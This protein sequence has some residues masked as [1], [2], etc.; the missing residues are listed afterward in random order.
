MVF[1][2]EFLRRQKG[3]PTMRKS[4]SRREN[5]QGGHFSRG[6]RVGRPGRAGRFLL[7]VGWGLV[8]GWGVAGREGNLGG[9]ATCRAED[10]SPVSFDTA[11]DEVR[12]KVAD[13]VVAHYV[14]ADPKISRPYLAHVRTVQGVQVTRNHPPIEG[15]DATDHADFHPGVWLAFGDLSGHD[16]W[17]LKAKV[18]HVRFVEKPRAESGGGT[19]EVE[20]EYLESAAIICRERCRISLRPRA[21]GYLLLWESTFRNDAESF[22]FG[23]QE[24]MGLGLRVA[25]PLS[26][27]AGGTILDRQ[28]RRDEK[29]VWGET[30]PWCDYSGPIGDQRAGVT[31]MPAGANFRPSWFHARDYGLLVANPFGRHALGRG[32]TSKVVVEAGKPFKLTFGLWV[33][34]TPPEKQAAAR[35]EAFAAFERL[36]TEETPA[37]ETDT[38]VGKR[39]SDE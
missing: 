21:D 12:I 19:F 25:T 34:A 23:D 4:T 33:Y 20:N 1:R 29:Q 16:D 31:L 38:A 26:V 39:T 14:F 7:V 17:R 3:Q 28:G 6:G 15:Q 2:Y 32:P 36:T 24:E 37:G 11:A 13:R 10:F 22:Y 8:G 30:S 18:R 35:D 9:V 5:G 27:R